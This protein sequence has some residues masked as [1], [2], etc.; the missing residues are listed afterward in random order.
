MIDYGILS[1]LN[2]KQI[3]NPQK[4]VKSFTKETGLDVNANFVQFAS[5][6]DKKLLSG[7][8]KGK[9]VSTLTLSTCLHIEKEKEF[10]HS[11]NLV[12]K[13]QWNVFN[14]LKCNN[15]KSKKGN[16]LTTQTCLLKFLDSK[17]LHMRINEDLTNACKAYKL[18]PTL[19]MIIEKE[20]VEE[21]K[22]FCNI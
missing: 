3:K 12:S 6:I 8:I 7:E 13:E 21:L 4:T 15:L 19:Q 20:L 10:K 14:I 22:L 16:L 2:K 1:F 5:W 18:Q 9:R 11:T 17:G